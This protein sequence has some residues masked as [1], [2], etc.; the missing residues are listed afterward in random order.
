MLKGWNMTCVLINKNVT[1]QH[2]I[3]NSLRIISK[4][5]IVSTKNV[6]DTITE[7]KNSFGQVNNTVIVTSCNPYTTTDTKKQL[8]MELFPGEEMIQPYEGAVDEYA[9]LLGADL[10]LDFNI[11]EYLDD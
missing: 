4:P 9:G 10:P 1:S 7:V 11:I 6:M 2:G 3:Y 5:F 8:W